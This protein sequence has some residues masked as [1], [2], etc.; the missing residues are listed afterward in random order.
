MN[1]N[2]A[3]LY[4]NHNAGPKRRGIVVL[5]GGTR[6]GKT[7]A[8]LEYLAAV[9]LREPGIIINIFRED[10]ATCRRTV[11]HDF[12]ALLS[13]PGVIGGPGTNSDGVWTAGRWNKQEASW[14]TTTGSRIQFHGTNEAGKLHGLS[15][16][17][18]YIN[19]AMEVGYDAWVQIAYRHRKLL[20]IDYNPYLSQHWT[21][22]RILTRGAGEV[23]HV[24]TTYRDNPHLTRQ[25]VAE[26]EATEP[27]PEN[28]ARGTADAFLW[29]VYGLGRRGR[30]EGRVF[31][32]WGIGVDWPTRAACERHGYGVDFGAVDPTAVVE[33]ALHNDEVHVRQVVYETG[34][35]TSRVTSNPQQRSLEQRLEEAGVPRDARLWADSA[36]PEAIQALSA[37]GW[38]INA[39]TK[40]AD[41][42]LAGIDRLK[43][44]RIVVHGSLDLLRELE[45]YCWRKTRGGVFLEQPEDANNHAIDALRYWT[46]MEIPQREGLLA[47]RRRPAQAITGLPS[48]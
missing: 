11:A 3:T 7:W 37:A 35:V 38:R 17:I 16:D 28:I 26:I 24:V 46:A 22:D 18:A 29:D 45:S 23:L 31:D 1:A 42:V 48:Y 30:R 6:S 4:K 34:L 40:G 2:L 43:Q 41:S 13:M 33:C 20:L 5:E 21:Y 36:R 9:A 39:A 27:T 8:A 44:R 32:D 14:T 47:K 12:Q 25:Q 19:E 10:Q 15:G